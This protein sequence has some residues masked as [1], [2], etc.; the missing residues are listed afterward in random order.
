MDAA[1]SEGAGVVVAVVRDF[2]VWTGEK[3][4]AT[5]WSHG[6]GRLVCVGWRRGGRSEV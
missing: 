5:Y 2:H 1:W 4:G 3:E 6:N